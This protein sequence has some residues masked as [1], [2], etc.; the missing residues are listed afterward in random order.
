MS[1]EHLIEQRLRRAANRQGLALRKSRRDG[2]Y[3]LV[4][5]YTNFV[6]AYGSQ[7]GYGMSID[8]IAEE[9]TERA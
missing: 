5:P 1:T 8:A 4:D 3:M 9:L 6:V 7:N 2:S